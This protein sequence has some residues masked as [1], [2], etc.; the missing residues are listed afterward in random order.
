M[1]G[2]NAGTKPHQQ[3]ELPLLVA[4]EISSLKLSPLSQAVPGQEQTPV[5]A[6]PGPL[7]LTPPEAPQ[8]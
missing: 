7:G 3:L 5:A 1:Q 8:W 4:E 6:L 2:S